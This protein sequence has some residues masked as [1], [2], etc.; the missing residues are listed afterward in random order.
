ME[1]GIAKY[2]EHC[3]SI[4]M[5]CAKDWEITVE[6]MGRWIDFV[7]DYKT[8]DVTYMES[9]WWVFSEMHKKN[10]VY[11]DYKVMPYSTAL[12]TPLSNFEA[13]LNYK[14]KRDPAIIVSFPIISNNNSSMFDNTSMLAWTTTPWTLP[15]NLA[16]CVNEN[17][18][19][20]KFQGIQIFVTHFCTILYIFVH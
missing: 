8:L 18:D 2:N 15:S 9:V 6:R 17:I 19:Y 16:L 14:M 11:R 4:V 1:M 10:L 7:N 13:K 12:N 5:R 20:V 3:R